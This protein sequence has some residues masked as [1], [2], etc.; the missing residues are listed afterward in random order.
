MVLVGTI[1]K[2]RYI[3]SLVKEGKLDVSSVDGK[4]ESFI[5]K[6]VKN[7]M[8]GVENALVIAGSDRRGTSY[9][10]FT[11]SE[12]MGVSPLYWWADVPV[13]KRNQFI[14]IQKN[15]CPFLLL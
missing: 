13:R 7:P 12:A 6:V 2:S 4:W 15:M 8:K 11:V 14:L 9:G 10:L 1:G 5:I 3:D